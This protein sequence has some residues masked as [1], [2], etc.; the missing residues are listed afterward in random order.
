MFGT[1]I[2]MVAVPYQ[3]K[4]LTG[5]YVAV[6][7]VS[8]A[9]FVPMVVCGLWG[10]AIADAL[11]RRKIILLSELGLLLTSALLMVNAL[12]PAPAGLGAVRGRRALGGRRQPAAAQPGGADPA[13]VRH[14]QLAAAAVLSEPALEP[15]RDRRPG[16]S[17]GC[18]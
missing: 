13:V 2:T 9:E 1:F 16:A 12:L 15:R 4:E 18:W 11:D 8:L 14:D 7:L 17:A 3:M 5:S 10:G 6:G